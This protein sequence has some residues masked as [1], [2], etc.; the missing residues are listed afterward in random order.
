VKPIGLSAFIGY[1]H[2]RR[3][4]DHPRMSKKAALLAALTLSLSIS[5]QA[6]QPDPTFKGR[7]VTLYVAGPAGSGYDAYA[8]L[9]S[10][11]AGRYLPGNPD[12]VVSNMS[13]A[14]GVICANF[15]YR[16]APKDGTAIGLLLQ[17]LPEEQVLGTSGAQFDVA[18]FG[19]IGRL[20]PNVEISYTWHTVPVHAVADLMNRETVF[21]GIGGSSVL[22]PKLLNKMI[23]ARFKLVT[24]Y[25]GTPAANL[26]MERGEV[27]GATSSLNTIKLTEPDWLPDKK[28]N[29]LVQYSLQR[30]PELPNV[31]AVVELPRAPADKTALSFFASSSAIGRSI[32]APPGLP[33]QSLATWR[34]AFTRTIHDPAFIAEAQRIKLDL[35]PLPGGDLQILIQ[36]AMNLSATDRE[37]ILAAYTP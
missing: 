2:W 30:D 36:D 13:G 26:A 4:W 15:I 16:M 11:Y 3:G 21:A 27:E 24:G 12:V 35:D 6:Q 7:L 14:S 10:R 22:Y 37:R 28:I 8:R 17:W 32:V 1:G 33:E 19:W 5:V 34:T 25:L 31:P 20:S 29:V 9:F 18:K 23:G